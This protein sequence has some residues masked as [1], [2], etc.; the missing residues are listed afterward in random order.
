MYDAFF[1]PSD[2]CEA[3]SYDTQQEDYRQASF[4]RALELLASAE[5]AMLSNLRT[6]V[7]RWILP[8][9]PRGRNAT[10]RIGSDK[11]VEIEVEAADSGNAAT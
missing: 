1:R 8:H 3:D 2:D 6:A 9:L 10:I 7:H 5:E 11:P 4:A